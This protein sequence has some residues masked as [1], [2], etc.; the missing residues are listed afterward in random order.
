MSSAA[1]DL[2]GTIFDVPQVKWSDSHG[3]VDGHQ[4][5][6]ALYF[7]LP[8]MLKAKTCVVLGSGAGFV[9]MMILA[10]QRRLIKENV[11]SKLDVTLVDA[12]TGIWGLP[13]YQTGGD[14]DPDLK[15]VKQL[16]ADAASSFANIDYIHVDADHSYEG[17]TSDLECYFPK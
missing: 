12:H 13:V 1:L 15:L 9:P 5:A 7:C 2:M 8:Y 17:V 16:S 3:A 10:A 14:I 6:G 4:A 11:I